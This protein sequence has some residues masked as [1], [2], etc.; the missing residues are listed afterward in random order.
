MK[1]PICKS[2]KYEKLIQEK[3]IMQVC[4]RCGYKNKQKRLIDTFK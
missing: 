2:K 3:Q 1:C 4:R